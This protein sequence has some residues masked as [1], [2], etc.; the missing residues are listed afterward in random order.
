MNPNSYAV[1]V[2]LPTMLN[3]PAL[4]MKAICHDSRTPTIGAGSRHWF[5][6]TERTYRA[7]LHWHP[8]VQEISQNH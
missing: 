8:E 4:R 5:T 3:L 7:V 1:S 6:M 2:S